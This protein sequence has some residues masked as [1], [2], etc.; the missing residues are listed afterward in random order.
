MENEGLEGDPAP[1]VPCRLQAQHPWRTENEQ[2]RVKITSQRVRCMCPPLILCLADE[3]VE[4]R[5]RVLFG[6]KCSFRD[7]LS[8]H[9]LEK[10]SFTGWLAEQVSFFC[11]WSCEKKVQGNKRLVC[12]VWKQAKYF[13]LNN[14]NYEKRRNKYPMYA[15]QSWA[16]CCCCFSV[17]AKE[18]VSTTTWVQ[19]CHVVNR[20]VCT[21]HV[22][23]PPAR[24]S[25][26]CDV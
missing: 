4:E 24:S 8:Q 5:V 9:D 14:N 3:W 23:R 20:Y 10:E 7:R 15:W 1:G 6:N 18:K 16:Y 13:V 17:L 11:L 19:T 2:A 22:F 25:W 26:T 21:G 12:C